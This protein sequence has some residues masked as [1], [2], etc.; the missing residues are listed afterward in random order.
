MTIRADF[1]IHYLAN[2]TLS[3]NF[4]YD[5][6]SLDI[7]RAIPGRQWH[8]EDKFWS[9]PRTSL[10]TLQQQA[11]LH[12]IGVAISQKVRIALNKG[13]EQ[14]KKLMAAKVD[15]TPFDLPTNTTPYPFQYSGITYAKYAL[16]HFKGVL[17]ADDQGLGKTFEAL[18]IIA[19]HDKLSNVLVLCPSTLKYT[20]ADEIDL[21][22]PQLT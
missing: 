22:Y 4:E 19:M 10:K 18:S 3:V 14:H 21:H 9:I 11:G 1:S 16:H 6:F 13:K 2:G 7:I 15:T 5:P 8:K 12:G 17:I 20:W